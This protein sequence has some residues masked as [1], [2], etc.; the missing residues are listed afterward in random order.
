[1][2]L[3]NKGYVETPILRYNQNSPV[4]SLPSVSLLCAGHLAGPLFFSD[5]RLEEA[6]V[7]PGWAEGS[8]FKMERCARLESREWA[9]ASPLQPGPPHRAGPPRQLPAQ[10]RSRRSPQGP[11]GRSGLRARGLSPTQ[12]S[13][14]P[15][16]RLT[17]PPEALLAEDAPRAGAQQV[18][19]ASVAGLAFLVSVGRRGSARDLA[20]HQLPRPGLPS[21]L[22]GAPQAP[23]QGYGVPGVARPPGPQERER[24]LGGGDGV[25]KRTS[26][27]DKKFPVAGFC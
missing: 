7:R 10:L 8:R 21:R 22:K 24:V 12:R 6:A 27:G 4:P 20:W 23:T 5:E 17:P 18:P 26:S 16:P 13:E 1:M 9:V 2:Q 14:A 19:Q 25:L 15:G 11:S 3:E